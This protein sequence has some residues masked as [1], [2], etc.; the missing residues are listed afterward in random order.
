MDI[1]T[2]RLTLRALRPDDAPW[3]AR[4]ISDPLVHR[5][6][7]SVPRPYA[8][9]D[10]EAYVARHAR[11]V[12]YRVIEHASVGQGVIS[13]TSLGDGL[14]DLGYWLMRAAWGQG[15]MTEAARAMLYDHFPRTSRSVRSG[16]IKG[17]AAS[18]NVLTK[19]GFQP[20]GHDHVHS[21]FHGTEVTL[22][23]VILTKSAWQ[24][25]SVRP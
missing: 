21:V 19:L 22:E 23:K 25:L 1:A 6:L 9:R 17:N 10:A 20:D 16:W 8:L 18:Q 15:F 4:E 12:G 24:A 14:Y 5:W 3:I 2:P 13:L 11:D 7:Y